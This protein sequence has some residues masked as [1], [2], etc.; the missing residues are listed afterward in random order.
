MFQNVAAAAAAATAV[1]F[2]VPFRHVAASFGKV[3]QKVEQQIKYITEIPGTYRIT[4]EKGKNTLFCQND[5]V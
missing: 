5:R 4:I 1:P 2:H 3:R